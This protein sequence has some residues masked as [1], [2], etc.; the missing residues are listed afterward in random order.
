M[1]DSLSP[2]IAGN[3]AVI[4]H[5]SASRVRK[6]TQ[7]GYESN[8]LLGSLLVPRWTFEM[9]ASQAFEGSPIC[10]ERIAAD[11]NHAHTA[12]RA[13]R[14]SGWCALRSHVASPI[15]AGAFRLSVAGNKPMASRDSHNLRAIC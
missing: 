7:F 15:K 14:M 6:A 9:S 12:F 10:F 11:Y 2:M 8:A 1:R 3:G 13:G 5:R 4:M